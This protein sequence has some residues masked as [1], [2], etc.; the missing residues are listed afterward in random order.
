M[1][2]NLTWMAAMVA[3]A[4]FA[5]GCDDGASDKEAAGGDGAG[6]ADGGVYNGGG[7][8]PGM[9]GSPGAGGAPGQGA[10]YDP[11]FDASAPP[12][13]R[14]DAGAAPPPVDEDGDGRDDNF[15]RIV[16]N[17]FV[18]TAEDPMSTFSVDVDTASYTVGRRA[19]DE[20]RLP[21]PDG[22]RIEEYINFFRYADPAPTPD[23]PEP[24]TINLEAAPS[25]FGEGMHLLRVGIKGLEVPAAER[26][27][28]NLVFLVDVSGSMQ[29]PDKIGLVQYSLTQL[30][31]G[32]RPT[33]TLS[34]VT[35]AGADR[36]LL[37]PTEVG[38]RTAILDAIDSLEAGGST[39]APRHHHR[40]RAGA[41]SLRGRGH[42]PRRA[43]HRRRLQR[44]RDR[45][46]AGATRRVVARPRHHAHRAGLRPRQPERRLPRA[47]DQPRRGPVRLHRQPQRGPARAGPRPGRHA[48]GHRQGRE[49]PGRVR[50]R[51]RRP[52]PPGGLRQPRP[53]PRGLPRRHR[54][55]R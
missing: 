3:A 29:S 13:A 44:R 10:P 12:S 31:N 34:I 16:E 21:N 8:Y 42:Q 9:G 24:F 5:S 11:G 43:V 52:L 55:R 39:A 37:P 19:I 46:A 26:A 41:G 49:D 14:A 7:G 50:S 18:D 38:D 48:A 54:R 1:K 36:V 35:Y 6:Y 33:D 53:G 2:R 32:L 25:A 17:P 30:T 28:A 22:V 51:R 23:D 47:A 40:V 15:G 20:G 45:R 27:P 4:M